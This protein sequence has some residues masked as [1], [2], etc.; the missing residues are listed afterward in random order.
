MR[1]PTTP[2]GYAVIYADP[3]WTFRTRS[4]KGQGRSPQRH[5]ATMD[6]AAIAALPVADV[7]ARNASLFLWTTTPHLPAA[8]SIMAGWGF[9]YSSVAFVWVKLKKSANPTQ[10]RV[11]TLDDADCFVGMGYTTRQNAEFVLLGRRGAPKR[12]SAAVRQVVIAP[13]REHSRKPDQVRA[14]IEALMAGPYLELFARTRAPGWDSWGD[15]V[16]RFAVEHAP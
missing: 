1:L 12:R 4:A 13:R 3:A 8:L 9:V 15:E 10:L 7:A 16:E 14:R 6:L 2:G 5:Y 11:T